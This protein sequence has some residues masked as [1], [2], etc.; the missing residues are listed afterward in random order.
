M[1]IAIIGEFDENFRSHVAT[2]QAIEHSRSIIDQDFESKWISTETVEKNMELILKE[3]QGFWIAPGSPYKSM[4]GAI[5]LI[6]YTR[7]NNIPTFGTC[8]GFQ[9]MIIEYARNVLD[10]KDAEHAEYDPYASRLV[11]DPL[12]CDL[13]G[14]PLEIEIIN[15]KSKVFSIYQKRVI[16]EKYYCNFG[17]NPDYQNLFDKNGFK[18]VGS[19]IHNEARIVEL[20]KHPFF[21]ATLFVPQDNSTF[22]SPHKLVT[23]FIRTILK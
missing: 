10:L 20:E 15:E 6:E 18:I 7:K 22:N 2:N 4:K 17:L 21:I 23:E 19:D 8:G 12:S 1:K 3:F 13:K 9:H 11:V 14:D 16:K 5:D